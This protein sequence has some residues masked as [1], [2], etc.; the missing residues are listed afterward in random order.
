MRIALTHKELLAIDATPELEQLKKWIHD[1]NPNAKP[2][3]KEHRLHPY[4]APLALRRAVAKAQLK[5]ARALGW[6]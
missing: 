5:K 6:K 4:L 2:P 3:I 1:A